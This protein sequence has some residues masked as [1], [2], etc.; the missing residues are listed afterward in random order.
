MTVGP[1]SD[2]EVQGTGASPQPAAQPDDDPVVMARTSP[3]PGPG[4]GCWR[5]CCCSASC[6]TCLYFL[7]DSCE[8]RTPRSHRWFGKGRLVEAAPAAPQR[9]FLR[10]F[11]LL[12][13]RSSLDASSRMTHRI[14]VCSGEGTTSPARQDPGKMI[15]APQR[16]MHV[17]AADLLLQGYLGRQC[18]SGL[19]SRRQR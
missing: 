4:G 16:H 6:W 17:Q 10:A 8:C 19:S 5:S 1:A 11:S 15:T 12:S 18:G 3:A 9:A 7:R 13:D 14:S 2:P